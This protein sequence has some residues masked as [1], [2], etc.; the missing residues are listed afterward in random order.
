MITSDEKSLLVLN[1]LIRAGRDAEQGF[2]SAADAVSD[3]E[4]VEIFSHYAVR[5][6]KFAAE[7]EDRVRTLRGVPAKGG[8]V[9]GDVHRGWMGL[10]V[11]A[12]SNETHAILAEC[13]RGE[14]AAVMAYRKALEARDVDKQTREVIQRQYEFVQAAHDRIRQLR[15]SATYAHQ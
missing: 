15:D 2:L 7:L 14:D 1:A 5:R 12:A 9:V 11:A 3:P 6:A 4:L 8:T 13:E 10:K